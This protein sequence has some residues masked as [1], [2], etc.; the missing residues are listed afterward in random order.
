MTSRENGFG[1]S[2]EINGFALISKCHGFDGLIHKQHE[3]LKC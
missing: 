3:L 2:R 1:R